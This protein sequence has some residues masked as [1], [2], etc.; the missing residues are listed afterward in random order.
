MILKF[1]IIKPSENVRSFWKEFTLLSSGMS[2]HVIWKAFFSVSVGRAASIFIL[3]IEGACSQNIGKYL[4][5]HGMISQKVET[6]SD[7]YENFNC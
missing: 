2:C 6:V 1:F 7:C 4:G 3:K 5:L